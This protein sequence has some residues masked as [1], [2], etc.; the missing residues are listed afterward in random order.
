MI[1]P[2]VT[3]CITRVYCQYP[4]QDNIAWAVCL[5]CIMHCK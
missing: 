2:A 3:G 1:R 5:W 4:Y